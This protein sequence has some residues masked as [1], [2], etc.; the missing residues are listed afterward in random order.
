MSF[1]VFVLNSNGGLSKLVEP[2]DGVVGC[3]DCGVGFSNAPRLLS[4][5]LAQGEGGGWARWD[6]KP[7]IWPA[8]QEKKM[9][10]KRGLGLCSQE[11]NLMDGK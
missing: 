2:C 10:H 11:K 4:L 8:Y 6:G 5:L 3:Q 1:Q 7:G 9:N